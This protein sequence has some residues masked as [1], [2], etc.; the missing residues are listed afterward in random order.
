MPVPEIPPGF[1]V[2]LPVGKPVNTILPVA[3][4]HVG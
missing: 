3:S 4:A 2:Q 1:I